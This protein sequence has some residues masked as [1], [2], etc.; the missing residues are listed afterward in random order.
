MALQPH[1]FVAIDP[2][3]EQVLNYLNLTLW[4]NP[5]PQLSLPRVLERVASQYGTKTALMEKVNGNYEPIS[6]HELLS[7]AMATAAALRDSGLK[8]GGKTA[9]LLKNSPVW[10]LG[11]FGTLFAGGTMVPIYPTLTP[12]AIEYILKDSAT[13]I[14]ILEDKVQYRKI[15]DKLAALPLL[16]KI[17]IRHPEGIELG[18]Q[19]I[20]WQD[21][22]DQGRQS[23]PDHVDA[24]HKVVDSLQRDD[25]ASIVYTSGT[26][27]EPKGV[28]LTHLN[29]ISTVFGLMSVTDFNSND[30]F[31]SL[32]PLSHVFE[33]SFGYYA[34]L[35]SGSMIAYAEGIE[36]LNKN[37]Q[38]IQPTICAAVPRIF[39][40]IYTRVNTE[41][42]KGYRFKRSL[43]HWAS[44]VGEKIW[45]IWLTGLKESGERNNKR[46]RHRVEDH[47]DQSLRWNQKLWLRSQYWLAKQLVY[48]RIRSKFGGSIRYFVTGGAPLSAEVI[49]FFRNLQIIIYEGYGLTETS[50]VISFNYGNAY[51]PG[52]VGKLIAHVNVKLADNGEIL[53]KGPN[54]MQGYLNK[55][56]ATH[57]VIDDD[58]WFHTGDIG[59]WD[60]EH[61]LKITDRLKELI[62]LSTGKNVAPLPLEQRLCQSDLISHVAVIGNNR[63]YITALVF[64]DMQALEDHAAH[65][66]LSKNGTESL[67]QND[68]IRSYVHELINEANKPFSSFEQIKRFVI[69]PYDISDD[70]ELL[71]PT[72]K[73]KRKKVEEKF[74]D[75]I[76]KQLYPR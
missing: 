53:V 48:K 68:Q 72:L 46:L 54:V 34:A 52:T 73:L 31:L 2:L 27:G 5:D 62:V 6:F 45:D 33:R 38:E 35:I 36:T 16:R 66:G 59:E 10:V 50:P 61:F 74:K 55:P 1:P 32:L 23:L 13:E 58:G 24:I 7:D 14:L 21:F 3:K 20:S 64:P 8:P 4:V 29:F 57:E 43:F 42:I 19:A 49:T 25:V 18:D 75:L 26:T 76:E 71:T 63:K 51:K 12:A 30:R 15:A 39:E 67:C 37:F 9:L 44:G 22:L 47:P 17:V 28:M 56:E 11:D 69:A 65:R 60:D 41:L 40:K 70:T